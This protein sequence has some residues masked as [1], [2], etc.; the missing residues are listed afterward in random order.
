MSQLAKQL[1]AEAKRT[2]AK[3]LDLGNCGL[4]ELPDELFELTE[5][6]EL[7]LGNGYWDYQ[8]N[9][10]KANF[11]KNVCPSIS[12]L[13]ALK[14]L[15]ING[16]WHRKNQISDISFLEKLT[17]LQTL[18]LSCNQISDISFLKKL[19]SL[20]TLNLSCNRISDVSFLKKLTN[21]HTLHLGDNRISDYSFLEKLTNLQTLDLGFN[22][23]SDYSFLEK[24]TDLQSLNLSTNKISDYFF[25]EKSNNLQSLN[26]SM[27]EI[28]DYSFLEKLTNLLSLNL[29][30]NQISDVSFLEKLTSLQSLDLTKN[31]IS[32]ISFLEK[33]I[34]LQSLHL[35]SNR[36]SDIFFLEKLTSLQSL[37]LSSNQISDISFLEK[38]TCLQLLDLL[39]NKISD[40]SF[41]EK[42]T[43]LQKLNLCNNQISDISS[44]QKL[45]RL[46]LLDFSSNQISDVS[47][48]VKLTSLQSLDL[49]SNKISDIS[50]LV[51]LTSLQTLKLSYNQVSDVS[52]LEKLISLQTLN[53]S[54]NQISTI[55]LSFLN[56]LTNLIDLF[57]CNN[58][59]EN[60]DE[61]I[62]GRGNCLDDLL[63]Y[64]ED[65]EAGKTS[66]NAIKLLLTGNG[67]VGKTQIAKRF[68][69]KDDFVFNPAH[70]STHGIHLLKPNNNLP[71]EAA[72][73]GLDITLWDF[74]G[75][76][77][78]HA[79]HRMFM[80]TKA[81]FLLVWDTA[82]QTEPHH[83]INKKSYK[84]EKRQ[85]WLEYINH[86]SGGS[87]IILVQNKVDKDTD[88]QYN[89][90]EPAQAAYK[91]KYKV[92]AFLQV[93]AKTSRQF[94]TIENT[95]IK[96]FSTDEDLKATLL[97]ELPKSWVNIRKRIEQD[98][99][100]NIKTIT[101]QIFETY[102]EKEGI[103]KSTNTVL[104]FLHNTGV[105]FYKSGY[106]SNNIIIDQAW[107]INAVYKVLD[108]ESDHFG[109][110]KNKKGA[111]DFYDIKTVWSNFLEKEQELFID[112]MLSCELCLETTPNKKYGTPFQD[113]TFIVPQFLPA[114]PDY[115]EAY[116]DR[117]YI[118]K[119]AITIRTYQFLPKIYIKRFIVKA[120]LFAISKARWANGVLLFYE[121]EDSYAIVEADYKTKSI[122]I[123]ISPN[124]QQLLKVIE[125]ELNEIE[126][127][128]RVRPKDGKQGYDE[129]A[130]AENFS[131]KNLKPNTVIMN[132]PKKVFI[133]YSHKDIAFRER[134]QLQ[135][136][137]LVR[138]KRI[139]EV[140]SDHKIK[141]G[142]NWNAEIENNLKEADI[143]F[144]LISDLFFASDFIDEKE[145]PIVKERY[146][147]KECIVIPILVKPS[148]NWKDSGW[149][150]LQAIPS[151]AKAGLLAISKWADEDDAWSVVTDEIKR[152]LQ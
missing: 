101:F 63:N 25:L 122:N 34:S 149:S 51:K 37:H 26:L 88:E 94:N 15:Q 102:C 5:L 148:S 99:K 55:E 39:S 143:V 16:E 144:L 89:I 50:F 103:K 151:N 32:D 135:L 112:F 80:Q 24:L 61:A 72:N 21:L 124:C 48:L 47:F 109:I 23:I 85:Y 119:K 128:G 41:L 60:I 19:T 82:S 54:D 131:F 100:S 29:S 126:G 138:Q 92:K 105:L 146:E 74:G 38:L 77:L 59:L 139:A 127:E 56:K 58:P 49:S 66:N 2:N 30:Y 84:N 22:K 98:N 3:V 108:R 91:E 129:I 36:I 107:A 114:K 142:G 62:I 40:I 104:N 35:S 106:F 33:L 71:C 95:I 7:K 93:S 86:F 147:N 78:Y 18:N 20:Q 45:I 65:L 52:F 27:N 150:F 6:E 76:D 14:A 120:G 118:S 83:Y 12:N 145:L 13:Q 4:T 17:S 43:S 123:R 46:Q 67:N 141:A 137:Q 8:K 125:N 53:L 79:T 68:V 11:I 97:K 42:L 10:G 69:E 87:P 130:F 96:L 113:R 1:I 81:V 70:D 136:K 64:M 57:L 44:L 111:L 73:N 132:Q 75:Q 140:W 116:C 152:V 115:I 110:L 134:L 117:Y 90:P 133:S 121:A 31:K 28:S 9:Y